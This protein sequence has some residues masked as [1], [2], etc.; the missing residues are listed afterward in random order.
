MFNFV[1]FTAIDC[2]YLRVKKEKKILFAR[3]NKTYVEF[4]DSIKR[5]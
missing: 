5:L 4:C 3:P 2:I 1:S